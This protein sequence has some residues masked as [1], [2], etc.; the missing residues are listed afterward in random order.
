MYHGLDLKDSEGK[1]M[2]EWVNE[3]IARTS[4]DYREDSK[5]S[6]GRFY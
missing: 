3:M 4:K 5:R 6:F 1:P 2:I